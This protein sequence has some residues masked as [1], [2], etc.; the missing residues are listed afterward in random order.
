MDRSGDLSLDRMT[1]NSL[2]DGFIGSSHTYGATLDQQTHVATDFLNSTVTGPH[3]AN[4][5]SELTDMGQFM[6]FIEIP[7]VYYGS[8]SGISGQVSIASGPRHV[9]FTHHLTA[10]SSQAGAT[11][12]EMVLSDD[13]WTTAQIDT[14]LDADRAV[15]ITDINGDNWLLILPEVTDTI[16]LTAM[17]PFG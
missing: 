13:L 10:N 4:N 17:A 15:Q 3:A 1:D 5:P 12:V 2:I 14:W 9:V 7:E 8:E 11:A 16:S 6:Q